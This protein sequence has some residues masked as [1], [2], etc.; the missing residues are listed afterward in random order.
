MPDMPPPERGDLPSFVL[1][2]AKRLGAQAAPAGSIVALTQ[3]G[4]MKRVLGK[5]AWMSF[6]ARQSIETDACGFAWRA[7]S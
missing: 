7:R 5:D 2:L 1:D 4:T 6:T 3:A